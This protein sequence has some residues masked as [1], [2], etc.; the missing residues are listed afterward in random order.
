M[1][2]RW[3]FVRWMQQ[4]IDV[5]DDSLD[6]GQVAAEEREAVHAAGSAATVQELLYGQE[7]LRIEGDVPGEELQRLDLDGRDVGLEQP[8]R[9]S[10]QNQKGRQ[11]V[12]HQVED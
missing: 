5:V 6:A 4:L 3:M 7:R 11:G 9:C 12:G 1:F 8:S 2:V 10:K